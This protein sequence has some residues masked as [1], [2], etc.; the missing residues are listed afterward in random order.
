MKIVFTGGGTGGHFYPIIAIAQEIRQITKEKRLIDPTLYFFAPDPYNEKLLFDNQIYFKQVSAGK[1]RTYKSVA[2]FFDIFKTSFGVM[3]ALWK[4]FWV[5]PDVIVS[6]G[7]YGSFPVV[8]AG[9]I[10]GIPIL[11]HESDSAPGRVN[12]WAGKFADKIAISYP[13]AAKYFPEGKTA[14]TGNPVRDEIGLVSSE[15]AAEYLNLENDV[16]VIFILGG[17]QGS[18]IINDVIINTLS[19]LVENYQIIHQTGPRNF[20]EIKTTAEAILLDSPHKSRYRPFAYLDDVAM[21]MSAGASDLVITRA[22]ST[23]FEVALW[24]IPSVVI[25]ITDSNADHQRKNAY[26]YARSGG[27]TVIE[28]AN[29]SDDI[30]IAEITRIMENQDSYN[31]MAESAKSF[32]KPRA[33]RT[34][35]EETIDLAMHIDKQGK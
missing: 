4:V 15:G 35:A 16:P 8:M 34:I 25:P 31:Q 2:N 24:G 9:K 17:S 7:G 32:A 6:K 27:G 3:A 21:R 5:Y 19:K 18:K 23:L 30:L 11:V 22:G 14:W 10:L 33:A 12:A 26:T 28:E 13:E 29:L 20:D 1:R